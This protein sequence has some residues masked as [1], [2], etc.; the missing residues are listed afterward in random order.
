MNTAAFSIDAE[1]QA[2]IPPL[3]DEEFSQLEQ[4]LIEEGCRDALVVWREEGLLLDGHNRYNICMA[5]GL[6]FDAVT[7]PLPDRQAAINWLIDNQLGRRNLSPTQ[8]SVLRGKRYNAEKCQGKRTDL[9]SGQN[10]QK[11]P[12]TDR[13]ATEWGVS[14]TTVKRDGKLAENYDKHSPDVQRDI[15]AGEYT[16]QDIIAAGGD[17]EVLV[18]RKYNLAAANHAIGDTPGYDGDEWYTPAE[19]IESARNV[20]GCIDLDPASCL[21]AQEIVNAKV[22][23]TKEDDSL[24]GEFVWSG[25]V[26]LNPPYS[27]PLIQDFT[28]KVVAEYEAGNIDQAI[29]LVNNSSDTRWF[30]SLLSKF[31]ACFTAGRVKFWRPNHENFGTRQGQTIFYMGGNTDKFAI[32]FSKHGTVVSVVS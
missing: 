29:V 3:S 22:F 25:N 10:D 21:A 27:M 23:A 4:N 5:K 32:E 6:P 11:L 9:T 20:M 31:P 26:W 1:F 16:K 2:L 24:R 15:M 7:I 28:Q 17:D 14:P 12:T 18:T 30:Q 19:F 8:A 13:L